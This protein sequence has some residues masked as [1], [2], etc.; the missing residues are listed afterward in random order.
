MRAKIQSK[1]LGR[2]QSK[3]IP[4]FAGKLRYILDLNAAGLP[5][6]AAVKAAGI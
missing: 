5:C 2:F 4:S 3:N 6:A 1:S